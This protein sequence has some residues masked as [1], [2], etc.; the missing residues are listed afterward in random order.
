MHAQTRQDTLTQLSERDRRLSYSGRLRIR[1]RP[2]NSSMMLMLRRRSIGCSRGVTLWTTP[3]TLRNKQKVLGRCAEVTPR[4][5][6]FRLPQIQQPGINLLRV[7]DM[8]GLRGGI[9]THRFIEHK[10]AITHQVTARSDASG[11][12]RSPPQLIQLCG[13]Q[14]LQQLRFK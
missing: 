6:I 10:L 2:A 3:E 1:W 12:H 11:R 13:T 8:G 5:S 7:V 4:S 14:C 9:S